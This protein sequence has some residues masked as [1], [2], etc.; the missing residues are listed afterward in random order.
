M[1]GQ[2]DSE[3]TSFFTAHS[4]EV[5]PESDRHTEGTMHLRNLLGQKEA[6]HHSG[7]VNTHEEVLFCLAHFSRVV[8]KDFLSFQ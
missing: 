3:V 6:M 2:L 1:Q 8:E 7:N 4:E 5:D